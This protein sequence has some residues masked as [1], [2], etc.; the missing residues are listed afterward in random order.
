MGPDSFD[1]NADDPIAKLLSSESRLCRKRKAVKDDYN[2]AL[3]TYNKEG[4]SMVAILGEY[5]NELRDIM[6]VCKMIRSLIE[7]KADAAGDSL[8]ESPKLKNA[9]NM[10]ITND[11]NNEFE[12]I[13]TTFFLIRSRE[14]EAPPACAIPG[15][16]GLGRTQ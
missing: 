6:R 9:I 4:S 12:Q 14:Q 15:A 10:K 11:F 2:A 5:F 7:S 3:A 16:T 13:Q 8:P 1:F